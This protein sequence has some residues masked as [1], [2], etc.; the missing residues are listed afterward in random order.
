MLDFLLVI[1]MA[2]GSLFYATFFSER[3]ISDFGIGI[4]YAGAFCAGIVGLLNTPRL[5]KLF[6]NRQVMAAG[7][8]SAAATALVLSYTSNTSFILPSFI[9]LSTLTLMVSFSM[10]IFLESSSTDGATGAIRAFLLTIAN[11]SFAL[12]PLIGGALVSHG[13]FENL[14]IWIATLL[15]VFAISSWFAL[16]S[17]TDP[18]YEHVAWRSVIGR[19]V[20]DVDFLAVFA[21]GFLLRFFYALTAIYLPLYLHEHLGFSL[22]QLGVL[23]AVMLIPFPLIQLPLGH[24]SDKRFGEKEF[25]ATGFGILTLTTISLSFVSGNDMAVWAIALAATS[26]GAAMIEVAS[27][28]YFFKQVDGRSVGTISAYR[29]LYPLAFVAAPLVGTIALM[30]IPLQEI[31][32]LF[33]IIIFTGLPISL[34]ITDTR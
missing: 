23:F 15:S 27:E 17:F 25:L 22:S 14:F 18:V 33:G 13:H 9:I 8:L 7:A 26:F 12:A 1:E 28:S 11:T 21:V 29:M 24:L 5:L 4:V 32:I 10:D 19:V 2:T 30:V 31:F 6:G 16:R 20:H 3:G 34:L